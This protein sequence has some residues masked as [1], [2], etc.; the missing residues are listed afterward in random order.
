[1]SQVVGEEGI[2]SLIMNLNKKTFLWVQNLDSGPRYLTFHKIV[3]I[4]FISIICSD[5]GAEGGQKSSFAINPYYFASGQKFRI[6]VKNKI[7]YFRVSDPSPKINIHLVFKDI[8]SQNREE[9]G[10]RG[11]ENENQNQY[12]DFSPVVSDPGP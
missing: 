10:H 7:A 9:L 11:R 1:M 12:E 4:F 3:C 2:K 5:G 8:F 6:R